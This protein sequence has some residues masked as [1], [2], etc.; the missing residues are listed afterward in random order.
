MSF[1]EIFNQLK[2]END[3]N[4]YLLDSIKDFFS[5]TSSNSN[6]RVKCQGD[7]ECYNNI[8]GTSIYYRTKYCKNNCT[9]IKCP[10]FILCKNYFPKIFADDYYGLCYHCSIAYK[11]CGEGKG[12]LETFEFFQCE[13]CKEKTT[14]IEQAFCDHTLCLKCFKLAH[15]KPGNDKCPICKIGNPLSK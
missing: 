2:C 9:L 13:N 1:V 5:N 14:C 6:K 7:G 10:N 15:F 3:Y 11:P 4:E 12:K 8:P